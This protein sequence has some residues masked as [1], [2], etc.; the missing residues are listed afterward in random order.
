M[1]YT[2]GN[3]RGD[4]ELRRAAET[5]AAGIQ[6]QPGFDP[7]KDTVLLRGV[8]TKE[9]FKAAASE[10]NSL[11]ATFGKVGEIS[12]FAHSGRGHGPVFHDSAGTGTQFELAEAA[13]L[14]VNWEANGC[15][16]F[17]GCKTAPYAGF[18]SKHQ[19]VTS[20]GFQGYSLFSPRPDQRSRVGTGGPV[21]MIDTTNVDNDGYFA[22][23]WAKL[24]GAASRPLV[25]KDPP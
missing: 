8:K 22:G 24:F 17:Y 15:A 13:L 2:T 5:R 16:R 19:G 25:R 4:D 10:A 14:K 9:D 6:S 23:A 7:K 11:E 3:S 21:Y 1:T 20:Y 12:I 18:F